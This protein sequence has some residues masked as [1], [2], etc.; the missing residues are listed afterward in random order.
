MEDT[1]AIFSRKSDDWETPPRFFQALHEE[2]GFT[3]DAAA[4]WE[5]KKCDRFFA[6]ESLTLPW[7]STGASNGIV[8]PKAP[9]VWLNPPYSQCYAF[10]AK[11]ALEREAGCTVVCLVPSRT[12]T[13]WW[14]DFVWDATTHQPRPG[15]SV[16]FVKGR[17]KFHSAHSSAPFPSTIIIF[18]PDVEIEA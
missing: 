18:T 8:R 5:N 6:A 3:L 13:K 12:D 7:R 17:I 16:R 2:F 14:H 11:A 15:V 1:T 10:L 4:T 9:V